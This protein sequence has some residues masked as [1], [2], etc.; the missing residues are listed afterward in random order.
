MIVISLV[1]L[2]DLLPDRY[3]GKLMETLMRKL[4]KFKRE[5]RKREAEISMKW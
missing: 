5:G 1:I 4:T 3:S 2:I